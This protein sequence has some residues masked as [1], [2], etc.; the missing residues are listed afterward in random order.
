[1]IAA[2]AVKYDPRIVN[3]VLVDFK[4]G[5]A[6]EPFKKLPHCV[7]IATNLMGNAVERIFIA[8]KAEMDRRAKLLADGRVGDLVDY[9]KRV[10]PK[11]KPGDPLPNTFPHLFVIVDEFAEM[12]AQNPEYKAQFESIT[13]LGRAF[14]VTLILA[15]QRPAGAVTDQMRSNMKFRVCLR[16]ETPE[17][18][19]ELLKRPDAARL[20]PIGGRGYIQVGNDLLTEIQV[21]WAGAEWGDAK[22]DPVYTTEEI[23][24]A[25][26]LKPENKP[27]LHDR[28]DRGR[29][30][31]RGPSRQGVPKQHKPWPDPLPETLPLNLPIDASYLE[32][33]HLGPE[34]TLSPALTG[35]IA[36]T[37]EKSLWEPFDWQSRL[38]LHASVG[39]VDDPF[40]SDAAPADHRR[41]RRP[42]RALWRVGARQEHLP[43]DRVLLVLAAQ[44]SPRRAE[45]LRA[46]TLA[47]AG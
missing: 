26:N 6:F 7:D 36:N 18:S 22:P 38:P 24:E 33:G 37:D 4:G 40:H 21:A 9:R 15:T 47:A 12:I 46:S 42:D 27:G 44:R 14:G 11:L 2:M 16:V 39:V 32:G 1:M 10:I 20:P 5:A 30:A 3:F 13:R 17:D 35:W 28:L 8:I 45:H 29:D 43:E 19:K 31:A 34:V 23:L 41:G 25:M